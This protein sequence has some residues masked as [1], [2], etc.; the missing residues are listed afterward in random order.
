MG[1]LV[2]AE[3]KDCIGLGCISLEEELGL[4]FITDCC[5]LTAFTLFLHSLTSLNIVNY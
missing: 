1:A 3:L 2:P 4:C 5:F